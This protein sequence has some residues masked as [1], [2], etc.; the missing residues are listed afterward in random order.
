MITVFLDGSWTTP[1][2]A[3]RNSRKRKVDRGV[4]GIRVQI[5]YVRVNHMR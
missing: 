2:Y 1:Y 3:R 5:M 4:Q